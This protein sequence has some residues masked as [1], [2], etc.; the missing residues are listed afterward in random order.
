M[1][2][3]ATP[4]QGPQRIASKRR[5]RRNWA[6]RAQMSPESQAHTEAKAQAMLAEMPLHELR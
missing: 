6:L 5:W 4:G 3:S 1:A 2:S